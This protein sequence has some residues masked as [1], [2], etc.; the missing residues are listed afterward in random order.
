VDLADFVQLWLLVMAA[1]TPLM[2]TE[3]EELIDS[4][5]FPDWDYMPGKIAIRLNPKLQIGSGSTDG[6]GP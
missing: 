4:N 2:E 1:A 6:Y 3:K 5:S